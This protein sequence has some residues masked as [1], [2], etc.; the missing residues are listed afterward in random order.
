MHGD[1]GLPAAAFYKALDGSCLAT[2]PG[3]ASIAL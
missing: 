1:T 2:L 3:V